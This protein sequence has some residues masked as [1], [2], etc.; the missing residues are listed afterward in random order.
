MTLSDKKFRDY[1]HE[2]VLAVGVSFE[3]GLRS[4][5]LTLATGLGKT[6]IAFLY[7]RELVLHEHPSI[8]VLFLVHSLDILTQSRDEFLATFPEFKNVVGM[9]T[10]TEKT[11]TERQF[12]FATFQS[13][14]P[15]L[16]EFAPEAFDYIVI[17]EAHHAV[18]PSF[19]P[20]VKHFTGKRLGLTATPERMDGL[21]IMTLFD[22]VAYD[23]PLHEA[24][25]DEWLASVD[26]Y[27]H[28]DNI[29]QTALREY[30]KSVAGDERRVTK[31]MIDDTLFLSPREAAVAEIVQRKQTELSAK[32]GGE[33]VKTI[34]FFTSHDHLWHALDFYPDALPYHSGMSGKDL[35]EIFAWFKSGDMHEILVVDKFNEGVDIPDAEL[36]VFHRATD[37]AR[38]WLQQLGRGTRRTDMKDRLAVL[39]FVGNCDRVLYVSELAQKVREYSE[40][41]GEPQDSLT[42]SE[43][44]FEISFTEEIRDLL[45]M[46]ERLK[47]DFYPTVEE[48][49]A[50]VRAI[51][52]RTE[53]EYRATYKRDQRL[54]SNPN[55]Y[56]ADKGWVSWPM[57]LRGRPGFYP[58]VEEASI[59]ARNLGLTCQREY[60]AERKKD[61]RLPSSPNLYYADKGWVSW[62]T[63]LRLE[64]LSG[65]YLTF[66]EASAAV[67]VLGIEDITVYRVRRGEDPRLPK[68]PHNTYA[69]RGW[70]SWPH[71]FGRKARSV[72]KR[73][74]TYL[75]VEVAS[76]AAQKLGIEA[77][78]EY[79]ARYKEDPLLP[80]S[81]HVYYVD[82]G[83]VSWPH[84]LGKTKQS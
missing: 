72:A 67:R 76:E 3:E 15:R 63:F 28:T 60:I 13:M 77:A 82:K 54:P 46:L 50:S 78:H 83:W 19:A 62:G 84:F 55:S 8:R 81:P 79:V 27:L 6:H 66:E 57:F 70:V 75:T 68:Q 42:I 10:G 12:L 26:Y 49:S 22:V 74:E 65:Y 30:A 69:S 1:Q 80:S 40:T 4:V 44:P 16:A 7:F 36:L 9:L 5:L 43:L 14:A 52:I 21:D 48:A 18:A 35:R 2:A 24:I 61:L 73:G 64:T 29:N 11:G 47:A 17:D 31:K 39:D 59:A 51:K 38:I 23:Y 33:P 58:T 34:H 56:Y 45:T 41:V 53:T 32:K 71:F 20:V 25:V 37:S